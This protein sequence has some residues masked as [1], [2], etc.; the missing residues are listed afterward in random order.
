MDHAQL[1]QGF[2]DQTKVADAHFL[3]SVVELTPFLSISVC[4]FWFR[5]S[6][7]RKQSPEETGLL[8]WKGGWA[9]RLP[10][11]QNLPF[12]NVKSFWNSFS[13]LGNPLLQVKFAIFF[14]KS[15]LPRATTELFFTPSRDYRNFVAF[16]KLFFSSQKQSH[17]VKLGWKFNSDYKNNVLATRYD[18]FG[19][20]NIAGK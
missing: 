5:L 6:Q 7:T 1:I 19:Y 9:E 12:W 4:W 16:W 15:H 2:S 20:C 3:V 14:L 17:L 13:C 18:S 8:V 11:K 10:V